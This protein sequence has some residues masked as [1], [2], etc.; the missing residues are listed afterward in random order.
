MIAVIDYGM[1]NIYSIKNALNH[2]GAES[3]IVSD[4]GKL[5]NYDALIIPGVGSFTRTMENLEQFR[6][7]L[8]DSLS[9]GTPFLGI[10]MGMQALFERSEEGPG[11]GLGV[12]PGEVIRF[13]DSVSVPQIGWNEVVPERETPLFEGIDNRFFYF[14][15][16]YHCV[17]K[18]SSFTAAR[19]Q[20]GTY[21]TA[22]V[23]KDNL[24]AVQFHPE[25]SGESGL[26]L[27]ENFI[28][29]ARC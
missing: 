11:E 10:C 16:S 23:E 5:H 26:K 7:N 17:P 18:D 2:L 27:L 29:Y 21:F 3:R 20:H 1:G 28:T 12:I 24:W 22:A 6:D 8:M 19:A 4:P 14:V 15:H 13:E 9:S 25:K